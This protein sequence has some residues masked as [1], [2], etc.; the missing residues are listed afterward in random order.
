ML[1]S[2]S[3][4]GC[5]GCD[6]FLISSPSSSSRNKMTARE[7]LNKLPETLRDFME[8]SSSSSPTKTGKGDDCDDEASRE[9]QQQ[10]RLLAAT[11]NLRKTLSLEPP[12]PPI[13]QVVDAGVVP[14]LVRILNDN[15]QNKNN[16]NGT[17]HDSKTAVE[18][19]EPDDNSRIMLQVEPSTLRPQS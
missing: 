7:F 4:H 3:I 5:A 19:S 1:K 12:H 14:R 17:N 13:Q 6:S 15:T 2:K 8:S 11:T 18:P 9:Q 16:S 10:L